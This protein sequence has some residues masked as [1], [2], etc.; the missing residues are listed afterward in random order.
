[1]WINENSLSEASLTFLTWL[2]PGTSIHFP[3]NDIASLLFFKSE[4]NPYIFNIFH[5]YIYK[6]IDL[7]I[8]FVYFSARHRG[9]LCHVAIMN[10]TA[11]NTDTQVSLWCVDLRSFVYVPRGDTGRTLFSFL[12]DFCLTSP[13]ER[14]A[15]ILNR[16]IPCLL[17]F[18]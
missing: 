16:S 17:L 9:W 15:C 8:S 3:S 12:K 6:I 2:Y 13:V 18:S 1:M 7:Y 5:Q 10:R 11:T 4:N 14:A